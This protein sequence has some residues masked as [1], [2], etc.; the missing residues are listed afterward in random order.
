MNPRS[1]R[2]KDNK[3]SGRCERRR[4]LP[5]P[6]CGPLR[7][8]VCYHPTG[9]VQGREERKGSGTNTAGLGGRGSLVLAARPG[10]VI[11]LWFLREWVHGAQEHKQNRRGCGKRL[12]VLGRA[13]EDGDES[14]H[15]DRQLP[16]CR[17]LTVLRETQSAGLRAWTLPASLDQG[18]EL[19]AAI[20]W[21]RA[22]SG[23]QEEHTGH[24]TVS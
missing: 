9:L 1:F 13:W 5:P 7:P 2:F 3:S 6:A 18:S 10:P 16:W 19:G 12:P 20:W 17:G 24:C 15:C 21:S 14:W 8:A 22:L 11:K 4:S 23:H